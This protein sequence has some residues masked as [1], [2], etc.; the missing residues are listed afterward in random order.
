MAPD[1]CDDGST[2]RFGEKLAATC[3]HDLLVQYHEL[4]AE[5]TIS[6]PIRRLGVC[7]AVDRCCQ[8]SCGLKDVREDIY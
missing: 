5:S 4:L 7:L 3:R 8:C 1:G 6:I 2:G